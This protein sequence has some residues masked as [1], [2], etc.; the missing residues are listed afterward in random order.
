MTC[1]G[2]SCQAPTLPGSVAV[3]QRVASSLRRST[4]ASSSSHMSGRL[5]IWPTLPSMLPSQFVL[6]CLPSSNSPSL[7]VTSS[8]PGLRPD[9][10]SQRDKHERSQPSSRAKCYGHAGRRATHETTISTHPDFCATILCNIT[11]P[12]F[13]ATYACMPRHYFIAHAQT[14]LSL[15]P[16]S[17]NDAV[18]T[19]V[20]RVHPTGPCSPLPLH[21]AKHLCS[22]LYSG[23]CVCHLHRQPWQPDNAISARPSTNPHCTACLLH[24]WRRPLSKLRYSQSYA[25]GRRVYP[26]ATLVMQR[27]DTAHDPHVAPK[28]HKS[29]HTA[30]T[31]TSRRSRRCHRK[32]GR[33]KARQPAPAAAATRNS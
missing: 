4:L 20:A 22:F 25:I 15:A 5:D 14:E 8:A 2:G 7:W 29:K 10:H 33:Q 3:G 21:V 19:H 26:S 13:P 23:T 24:H 12:G 6:T 17:Q 30:R 9:T 32:L 11:E 16:P 28:T 27:C 18:S 1:A 31:H